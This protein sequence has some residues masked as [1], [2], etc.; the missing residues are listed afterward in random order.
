MQDCVEIDVNVVCTTRWNM[1]LLYTEVDTIET[2]LC[3]DLMKDTELLAR[4]DPQTF[5]RDVSPSAH[6]HEN[7]SKSAT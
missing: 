2:E 3:I 5:G 4:F 7:S 1:K 6:S